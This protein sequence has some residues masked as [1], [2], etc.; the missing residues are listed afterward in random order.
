MPRGTF[1]YSRNLIKTKREIILQYSVHISTYTL[2][3]CT[4]CRITLYH[5]YR[6]YYNLYLCE[7]MLVFC[8]SYNISFISYLQKNATHH[9]NIKQCIVFARKNYVSYIMNN[10]VYV[11][12]RRQAMCRPTHNHGCN[13]K[14]VINMHD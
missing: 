14:L 11:V 2:Y 9:E 7:S 10:T 8:H 6:F 1:D 12:G 13:R 5:I 4:L 3:S